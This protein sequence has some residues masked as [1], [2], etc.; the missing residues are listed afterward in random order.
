MPSRIAAALSAL[1]LLSVVSLVAAA[2]LAIV[3]PAH[4]PLETD[5]VIAQLSGKR[6]V[7][8]GE[9]HERYDQHLSQLAIIRRFS[10]AAPGHW[11]IGVEY[12]QRSFQPYLDAYI[13][14]SIGEHEFLTRTEYF[15]RWGY[16]F[17]LY[18]PIFQ[19]AR[20]QHIPMIALN[21]ERELTD[22]VSKTGLAGLPP[23]DHDRLP[24]GIEK[25]DPAYRDR[26]R[27]IFD[28]HPESP[29]ADFE[30]FVDV[31]SVWD[32]TMGERVADRA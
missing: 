10:E 15:D 9:D 25:P 1:L 19:Y 30:K 28:E 7:F 31:Q 5:A 6:V 14:G 29:S 13:A 12:F 18:R 27:K 24:R 8:V 22:A 11:A 3:D 4:M 2:D 23:A 17:R 21:A 20:E 26:L 32:E 16:D